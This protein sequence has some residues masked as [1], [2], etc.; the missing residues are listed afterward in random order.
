MDSMIEE[1]ARKAMLAAGGWSGGAAA[2]ETPFLAT[3]LPPTAAG[4]RRSPG[5][6]GARC[7]AG[8]GQRHHV[9]GR[10]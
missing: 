8:L 7:E 3:P 9:A 10:E 2:R 1:L 6:C 4:A 5:T